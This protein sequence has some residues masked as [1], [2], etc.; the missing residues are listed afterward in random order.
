MIDCPAICGRFRRSERDKA[1]KL[2][3]TTALFSSL[4]IFVSPTHNSLLLLLI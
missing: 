3:G 4:K 1:E 2:W